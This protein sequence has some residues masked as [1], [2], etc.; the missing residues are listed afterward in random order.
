MRPLV[1]ANTPRLK[2][3][4][5]SFFGEAEF[6]MSLV[7]ALVIL[8]LIMVCL[9]IALGGGPNHFRSGFWYWQDP[10]AFASYK[11]TPPNDLGR[12][13]GFWK[14]LVQATF[15]YLGTELVGVAFGE[16]P[17]PRKNVPRAVKQTL[18]RIIFFYIGGVLVLG[19]ALPYNDKVLAEATGTSGG[20]GVSP[21][22][23]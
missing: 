15:A 21:L 14:S 20:K 9:V 11:Q 17:N 4:H 2:L 16:T 23:C 22:F 19:M 13:L 10:G 1:P 3:I 12:F 5:V 8:M 6:W 7:K 18:G